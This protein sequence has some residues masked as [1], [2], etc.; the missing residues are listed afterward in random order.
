M[1]KII[2]FKDNRGVMSL[3]VILGIGLFVLA[4]AL[5]LTGQIVVEIMRGRNT[6]AGD[7]SFFTAE[8]AAREGVYQ[9]INYGFEGNDNFP[10]LLNNIS[11]SSISFEI[12][13][14]T[15]GWAYREAKG[16]AQNANYRKVKS[17]IL[18]YRSAPAFEYAIY[19]ED[20]LVIK[21]SIN[22]I[23]DV[24]SNGTTT[25]KGNAHNI[26]G[27]LFSAGL[28][29]NNCNASSTGSGLEI[30]PPPT[31]DP[32]YYGSIATCTSTAANVATDCLAGAPSGVIFVDD[33]SSTTTLNTINLTGNLTIIGDLNL[34]GNSVITAFSDEPAAVVVDGNLKIA[35]NVRIY[36]LVYVTGS[37]NFAGGNVEIY[38]SL[39][40]AR[41]V[42]D[43]KGNPRIEYVALTGRP[44]GFTEVED[45]RIVRWKEE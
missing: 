9:R 18:L 21:G 6:I 45:P 23:G 8:A 3:M 5:T 22:I 33:P 17:T 2:D 14:S 35:G 38:G 30:I 12:A 29:G 1:K 41:G 10:L 44:G 43:I 25:C 19:S 20:D 24:F 36:G 37:T 34:G 40:S 32:Y 27:D 4:I 42:S 15:L 16:D 7:Q 28:T 39:I 13:T 31:I 11:T 26:D